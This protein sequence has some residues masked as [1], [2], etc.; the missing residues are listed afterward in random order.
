MFTGYCLEKNGY[1]VY[2]LGVKKDPTFGHIVCLFKEN[3]MFYFSGDSRAPGVIKG[4]YKTIEEVTKVIY[5]KPFNYQLFKLS[6]F[7]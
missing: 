5:E 4:P 6:E 2:L 3:G 1:E 7:H